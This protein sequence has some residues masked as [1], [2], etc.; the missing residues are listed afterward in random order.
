MTLYVFHINTKTEFNMNLKIE[1]VSETTTEIAPETTPQPTTQTTTETTQ[2]T[3]PTSTPTPGKDPFNI[4]NIKIFRM[5]YLLKIYFF[6]TYQ[7]SISW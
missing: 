4:S 1:T 2:E 7:F 3:M 5:K 6:A